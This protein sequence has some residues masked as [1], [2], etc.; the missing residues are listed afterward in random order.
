MRNKK[1]HLSNDNSDTE[2]V[3]RAKDYCKS[4]V[5]PNSS[6]ALFHFNGDHSYLSSSINSIAEKSETQIAADSQLPC[7]EEQSIADS[8]ISKD[9]QNSPN[10][11]TS[12]A[13]H[14]HTLP[15][16]ATSS[17]NTVVP[18]MF[19]ASPVK[20]S[21]VIEQKPLET[22]SPPSNLEQTRSLAVSMQTNV[23]KSNVNV[24]SDPVATVS[25][26]CS[27][28][29]DHSKPVLIQKNQIPPSPDA[30][31][32]DLKP[33]S[34]LTPPVSKKA[35]SVAS[36][37]NSDDFNLSDAD[38]PLA[39]LSAELLRRPKRLN[40]ASR[41]KAIMNQLSPSLTTNEPIKKRLRTFQKS[42][43]FQNN[44]IEPTPP[45]RRSVRLSMRLLEA[46]K[47]K[48][49]KKKNVKKQK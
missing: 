23:S 41:Y 7:K 25:K 30:S 28:Q 20:S 34:E 37:P 43:S 40:A 27:P 38:I 26:K 13:C 15:I 9:L 12:T 39:Q 24:E 48:A 4:P 44:S 35:K 3:T 1:N 2:S 36:S 10:H 6:S 21:T 19:Y 42:N 16:V 47:K 29:T 17:V 49:A 46:N 5:E 33:L 45:Q 22:I 18:Y 8:K 14:S 11:S 32:S 31:D